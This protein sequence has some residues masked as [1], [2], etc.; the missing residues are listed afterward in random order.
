[1]IGTDSEEPVAKRIRRSSDTI[2]P[3]AHV[4]EQRLT[5]TPFRSLQLSHSVNTQTPTEVSNHD[6]ALLKRLI[7]A[8]TARETI[9]MIYNKLV[10]LE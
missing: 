4:R 9:D 2:T 1:M 7:R 6:D 10:S 8:M 5:S 3:A